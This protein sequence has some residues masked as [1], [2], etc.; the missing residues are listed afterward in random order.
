MWAELQS[1]GMETV[2]DAERAHRLKQERTSAVKE[3]QGK[4]QGVA[5]GE[6]DELRAKVGERRRELAGLTVE[7]DGDPPS[8]DRARE[9]ESAVR[10]RHDKAQQAASKA[11]QTRNRAKG[12]YDQFKEQHIKT[13]AEFDHEAKTLAAESKALEEARQ[14]RT[15]ERLEKL[16]DETKREAEQ[17]NKTRDDL[18]S[19]LEAQSPDSVRGEQKRAQEAIKQLEETINKDKR[20]SLVLTTE[21]RTLGQKGIAEELERKEGD[22]ASARRELERI[23]LDAK[24]W[25]LL[26]TTLQEAESEAKAT[27]LA[28]V[29]DRL[30]PY[31]RLLFPE[32][33]LRLREDDFEIE[34]I[35]R[36]G[37]EEPFE[38]LSIGTREQIAVLTRLALADLLREK[39]KPVA[40]VLDDP[41]VNSD[42]ERFRRMRTALHKAAENV[43]IVVLTCHEDR[44]KTL[45][46]RTIRL[47]DCRV[48]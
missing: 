10:T 15:D 3:L 22:L 13:K 7:S 29:R 45:G 1:V 31:L 30:Q 46:T 12:L 11:E 17:R 32:A 41:L 36:G 6:L 28:P 19:K 44:Y 37:V 14:D 39:G 33:D 23:E 35:R 48:R 42:D 9:A 18:I 47:S 34:K 38:S 20:E 40:L 8:V 27:F 2:A 4:L 16:A 43:Q 5:G 24:A 21:L 25:K 26:S